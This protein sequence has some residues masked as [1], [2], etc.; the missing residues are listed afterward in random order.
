MKKSNLV[1]IK[2]SKETKKHLDVLKNMWNK[3]SY[4]Y[5]IRNLLMNRKML[6]NVVSYLIKTKLK[7]FEKSDQ[8]CQKEKILK[9]AGRKRRRS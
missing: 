8:L 4:D 5:I 6:V 7:D 9:R 1:A 2:I 3:K